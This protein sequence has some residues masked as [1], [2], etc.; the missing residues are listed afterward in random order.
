MSGTS[1]PPWPSALPALSDRLV[2][3]VSGVPLGDAGGVEAK[4]LGGRI[5]P[6]LE[7]TIQLIELGLQPAQALIGLNAKP[8][9]KLVD[10][11]FKQR[12]IE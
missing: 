11:F 1:A 7:G 12:G 3:P 8:A 9:D 5:Q 4:L 6:T 2:H 10:L